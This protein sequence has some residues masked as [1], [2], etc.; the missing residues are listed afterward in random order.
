MKYILVIA[1]LCFFVETITCCCLSDSKPTYIIIEVPE[2][3]S[4]WWPKTSSKCSKTSSCSKSSSC[5]K[6][7]SCSEEPRY[8]KSKCGKSS[9][10]SCD[11]D[12]L[13]TYLNF[14]EMEYPLSI[15]DVFPY[16]SNSDCGSY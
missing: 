12:K 4:D 14:A 6:S 10:K 13:K 8:Y 11:G 7:S 15:M 9:R 2:S 3:S 5:C 16:Y 1:G